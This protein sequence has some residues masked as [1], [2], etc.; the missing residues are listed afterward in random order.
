ML[1]HDVRLGAM[2]KNFDELSDTISRY[3]YGGQTNGKKASY[4][5]IIRSP[6]NSSTF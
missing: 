1:V 2:W 6:H 4:D 5:S 3:T